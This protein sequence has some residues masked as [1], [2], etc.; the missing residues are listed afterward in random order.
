MELIGVQLSQVQWSGRWQGARRRRPGLGGAAASGA[1]SPDGW[2]DRR[3]G[4]NRHEPRVRARMPTSP[5]ARGDTAAVLLCVPCV[6]RLV[7]LARVEVCSSSFHTTQICSCSHTDTQLKL[8]V[9]LT[10]QGSNGFGFPFAHLRK[11]NSVRLNWRPSTRARTRITSTSPRPRRVLL[12]THAIAVAPR[13]GGHVS[14]VVRR[15]AKGPP[16]RDRWPHTRR[17]TSPQCRPCL[18]GTLRSTS[19]PPCAPRPRGPPRGSN[20]AW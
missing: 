5:V 11:R 15:L 1:L 18:P 20:R 19:P 17:L 3:L 7:C 12:P 2:A 8:T 16:L 4:L 6:M 13:V 10:T 9:T 14:S